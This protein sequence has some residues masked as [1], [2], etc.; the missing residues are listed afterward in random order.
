MINGLRA[1]WRSLRHL[2]DWASLYVWANILWLILSLPIITAPAAWAGLVR[3]S[4][5][6]HTQPTADIGEF[7]AGFRESIGRGVIISVANALFIFINVVN[8]TS[9]LGA[10]GLIF[11]VL[12][13]IWILIGL[14]W[15][16][17]Q[18]YLWPLYYEMK[19]PTLFGALKNAGIM[20]Y[21]NPLFTLGIWFCIAVIIAISIFLVLPWALLTGSALAILATGAVFNR[22]E[23]SGLRKPI[24]EIIEDDYKVEL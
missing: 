14:I 18:F 4:R 1:G 2:N 20:L 5:V 24:H 19:V 22:L 8:F 6:A 12:R 9:Y 7:W 3:M 23:V 10:N 17:V 16:T 21:L 13:A 15:F 11:D